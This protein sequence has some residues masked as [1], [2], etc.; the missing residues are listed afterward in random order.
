MAVVAPTRVF[1][2]ATFTPRDSRDPLGVFAFV[3][4]A[5]GD[6]TGSTLEIQM[7]QEESLLKSYVLMP[8]A[9]AIETNGVSSL[10]SITWA[11]RWPEIGGPSRFPRLSY[12]ASTA[13]DGGGISRMLNEGPLNETLLTSD[14]SGTPGQ[15]VVIGQFRFNNNGDG[16]TYRADCWGYYWDKRSLLEPGSLRLP[17]L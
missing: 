1:L 3:G 5:T 17:F 13:G 9:V 11:M 15:E 7:T 8:K 16:D 2:N 10:V 6:A 14:L 12:I 4:L